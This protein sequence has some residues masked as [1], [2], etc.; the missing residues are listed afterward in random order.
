MQFSTF[1]L[2]DGFSPLVHCIQ[3]MYNVTENKIIGF[4]LNADTLVTKP[5]VKWTERRSFS[6]K[7]KGRKREPK[8]RRKYRMKREE[9]ERERK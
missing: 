4:I 3:M 6:G 8:E 9:R 7:T 1:S 5:T 2:I